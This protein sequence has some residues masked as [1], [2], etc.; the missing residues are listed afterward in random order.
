MPCA[1]DIQNSPEGV[2]TTLL[3]LSQDPYSIDFSEFM[4]FCG[5]L[6]NKPPSPKYTSVPISD[7]S[8]STPWNIAGDWY[9]KN[10]IAPV[11]LR[12]FIDVTL[13]LKSL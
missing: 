12:E 10:I 4:I 11:L 7:L 3:K 5:S 8:V 1:C 13:F 6:A 9:G 2:L